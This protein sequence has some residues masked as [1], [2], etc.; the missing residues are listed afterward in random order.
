[1]KA[2][3]GKRKREKVKIGAV[4]F[5]LLTFYFCLDLGIV[6]QM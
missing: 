2:N 5:F 3:Q 6:A 1:V 4:A